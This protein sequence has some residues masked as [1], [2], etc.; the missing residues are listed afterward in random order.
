M[1]YDAGDLQL[2]GASIEYVRNNPSAHQKWS[3]LAKPWF[4]ALGSFGGW[5]PK[6]TAANIG[7]FVALAVLWFL[8]SDWQFPGYG[9][10]LFSYSVYGTPGVR[11]GSF[12]RF[13]ILQTLRADAGQRIQLLSFPLKSFFSYFSR[14]LRRQKSVGRYLRSVRIANKIQAIL[15]RLTQ[16]F[17]GGTIVGMVA[18]ILT[19]SPIVLVASLLSLIV[20]LLVMPLTIF[21]FVVAQGIREDIPAVW[22]AEDVRLANKQ[23]STDK[24]LSTDH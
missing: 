2:F 13:H 17:L 4:L 19:R 10:F 20:G 18:T 1:R 24:D 22:H 16:I 9:V 23:E 6:T 12:M 21:V 14:R 3:R 15:D 11:K 5:E 7:C 8:H